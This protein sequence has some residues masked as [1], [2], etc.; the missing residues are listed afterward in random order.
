MPPTSRLS[1]A[2]LVL[3]VV[4]PLAA[5]AG[6]VTEP[7]EFDLWPLY[8]DQR[9]P[10]GREFAVL[11]PL[12]NFE[13]EGDDEKSWV[14]PFYLHW[15]HGERE[16]ATLV[17]LI[18]PLYVRQETPDLAALNVF[19]LYGRV[20]EGAR[21]DRSV[22]LFLT[23]WSRYAGE[24]DLARLNVFPLF[25]WEERGAGDR[26]G[27]LWGGT[28]LSA[29]TLDRTG[30]SFREDG[31]QPGLAV[32]VMSVLGGLVTL[33][34][35][36]DVGSHDDLRVLNLFA[37]EDWSLFVHRTPHQGTPGADTAR[38]VLF[39]FYWN[40]RHGAGSRTRVYWPFWGTTTR[41]DQPISWYVLFP[42][43]WI[44]DDEA[45]G[46]S[47]WHLP[48]PIIG[49]EET[50]ERTDFWLRPLFHWTG[51][52]DGHEWSALLNFL[53]YGRVGEKRYVRFLWIPWGL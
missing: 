26:L 19:P 49:R 16:E 29:L 53:G 24:D 44:V 47:A 41:E 13:Q 39:P 6:C 52:P 1:R 23:E 9:G 8:R 17:P 12:S 27:L 35:R 43:L 2:F 7:G 20:R 34:H 32:D 22:L 48:W 5:S 31:D 50:P 25:Q 30:L 4:V 37:N 10:D 18:P 38:T 42:L 40:V 33:F 45:R 46:R 14:F 36:D 28:L 51:H 15:R 3:L 21:T 11:W